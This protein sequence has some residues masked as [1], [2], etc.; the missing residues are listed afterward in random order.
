V[1]IEVSGLAFP[2]A[3]PTVCF[4]HTGPGSKLGRFTGVETLY[5]GAF[6]FLAGFVDSVVGGGGLIQ[7][8]A[9]FL[10][11]PPA[12][13]SS[14]P[15]VLGTNKM[16]SICGTGVAVVQYARRIPIHWHSIL[17]AGGAAFVFSLLGARVVTLL[18]PGFL[19]P[20]VFVLLVAVALYTFWS[21]NL[22]T[23]H[24]PRLTARRERTFG[25]LVGLA[26][27]F[28]DGFFGPGTGS[29]LIFA[30]VGWFGFDFLTASAS[31]KVINFATNLAAVGY[32]AT[33]GNILWRYALPMAACNVLGSLAGTR[34]AILR[35]NRF[36]R[37]LF[38]AVIAA[39]IL[40]MGWDLV[41]GNG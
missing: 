17:P 2:T 26:I 40:K 7:L 41:R 20:L 28:Y 3:A 23:L 15:A 37:A 9:L 11:L 5:L 33:T 25:V 29:F 21:R 14:I 32:F 22:G 8:P 31:A 27:G 16:S 39:L 1:K 18:K 12:L 24:A 38:L 6:A 19:R 35:G 13:A 36:I 10:C 4:Q 30:F 34:L